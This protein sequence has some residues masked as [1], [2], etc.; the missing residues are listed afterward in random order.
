[1]ATEGRPIGSLVVNTT[2]DS[3]GFDKGVT[4][5]R[6]QLKTAQT[7]TKATAAEFKALDDKLG[8]SKSKVS[9]LSDQLKIQERIVD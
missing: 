6:Q 5:L 9:G 8:E 4:A 2:L 1:M 7:A 3:T